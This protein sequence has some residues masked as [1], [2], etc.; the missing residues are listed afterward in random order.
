MVRPFR[1]ALAALALLCTSALAQPEA[2]P[3]K[4]LHVVVPFPAGGVV[5]SV[6]RVI[7]EKLA[8]KYGQP[9]VVENRPGAGG[10]IGTDLVAKAPA[11]G[12]TMLMVGTG[13][14]VLPQIVKDI[15]WSTSDFRAVLDIG[16]VPNVIVVNPQVPVRT[17]AELIAYAKKSPAPLT[18][19]S[20]GIGSSPHLS[21]EMLAQMAGVNLV[22]VPYKG[23]PE[24]VTDLLGGRISMMA[25]TAAL[26]MPHVKAGRLHALAVTAPRPIM[27]LPDLPTVADAAQLPGYEV[28]PWTGVFVPARTPPAI[29]KKLA[30]DMMGVLAMPDVKARMAQLG[31]E[32]APQSTS[33]FDTFLAAETR[34]WRDVLHKAGLAVR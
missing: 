11:D 9:V 27:A 25:L 22:H 28:Q 17:M 34:R 15:P 31:M 32:L 30:D 4:P 21:G 23:Q 16:S 1:A 18:Y 2:F 5:D 13:F 6:A 8:A 7:G 10:S 33:E 3:S 19:G 29:A 14:T 20:P 26:A 24:A 12:Y